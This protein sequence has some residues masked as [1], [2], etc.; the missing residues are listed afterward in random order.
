MSIGSDSELA[1][2]ARTEQDELPVYYHPQQQPR[3]RA[4]R[5]HGL[6]EAELLAIYEK[7]EANNVPRT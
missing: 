6:T 5:E 3:L 7:A 2:L 4:M 1:F